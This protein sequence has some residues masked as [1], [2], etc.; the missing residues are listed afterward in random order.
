V[1]EPPYG[2]IAERLMQGRVIPLLGPGANFGRRAPDKEWSLNTQYVPS[3]HELA[4]YLAQQIGFP[5]NEYYNVHDLIRVASYYADRWGRNPLFRELHS[6][7]DRDYEPCDIHRHLAQ[8]PAPLLII[9]VNYDD[10]LER[11]FTE[12]G[13]SYDVVYPVTDRPDLAG[14]L[15]WWRHNSEQP[16]VTTANKISIDL[17]NTTVIYK[18]RGSVARERP[19]LDSYV[20]T[21]DD[22]I[23]VLERSLVVPHSFM[24]HLSKCHFLFL[25]YGAHDWDISIFVKKLLK[26]G[27]MALR[28][29]AIQFRPLALDQ[30]MWK[31]RDVD[32]Y[33]AEINRFVER[34]KE[35]QSRLFDRIND[36]VDV[37]DQL[38]SIP[39][40]FISY[41]RED[42]NL[43]KAVYR[44][45]KEKGFKPW[46]DK[47]EI[48]PGEKWDAKIK[49]SLRKSDFLIVCMSK[50]SLSKRGYVQ[51][52]VRM[53]LDE[54][55][56]MPGN[57]IYIIPVRFDDCDVPDEIAEFQYVDW[58]QPGGPDNLARAI[59]H[60]WSKR[61]E[62][63]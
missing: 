28:S 25:G 45:L 59:S 18:I 23:Y 43:A 56:K 62:Q 48:L 32:V 55:Q 15:M 60:E 5:S 63:V 41:A 61:N 6:I 34:L 29:W 27:R 4:L 33:D 12:A 51:K 58:L 9:T 20:I 44:M 11:A 49:T 54:A 39:T 8:I 21:E 31:S 10:L 24:E 30:S 37:R 17:N 40:I 57:S 26:R 2:V 16:V 13:R 52:E 3:G 14:S 7:F 1:N 36:S 53:A 47:E 38:E 50:K 46:L 42:E 35:T 19:E 22:Y